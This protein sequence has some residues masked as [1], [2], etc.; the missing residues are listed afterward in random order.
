MADSRFDKGQI[1]I[2]GARKLRRTLKESA[3]DLEEMKKIHAMAAEIAA[4]AG[5]ERAP[6]GDGRS[7][8]PGR[9]KRSIRYSGTQSAAIIRAGSRRIPYAPAIHWGRMIWPSKVFSSPKRGQFRAFIYP[10]L[11]LTGGAAETE[12]NWLPKYIDYLNKCI[13]HV[14][15]K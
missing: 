5:I 14:E 1:R 12:S 4:K 10:H 13:A 9:L 11:F 6:V 7:G 3:Q 15:G 8:K 2:E